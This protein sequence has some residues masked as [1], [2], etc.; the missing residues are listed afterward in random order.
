MVLPRQPCVSITAAIIITIAEDFA[1]FK[2]KES[3]EKVV[4]GSLSQ[5]K[6]SFFH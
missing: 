4:S 6:F 1:R 3:I 2:L 5:V